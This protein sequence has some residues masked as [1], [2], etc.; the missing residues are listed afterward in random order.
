[1]KI[2]IFAWNK[3]EKKSF[4]IMQKEKSLLNETLNF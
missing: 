3:I 2:S 1:L 4:K